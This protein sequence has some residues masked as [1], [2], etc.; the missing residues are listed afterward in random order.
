MRP[1]SSNERMNILFNTSNSSNSVVQTVLPVRYYSTNWVSSLCSHRRGLPQRNF[2]ETLR[3]RHAFMPN[4]PTRYAWR[5]CGWSWPIGLVPPGIDHS[6]NDHHSHYRTTTNT[7]TK[8]KQT[9]D[10]GLVLAFASIVACL[11]HDV[12][13]PSSGSPRPR[14]TVVLCTIGSVSP[15]KRIPRVY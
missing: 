15:F 8:Q 7:D 14:G 11:V 12:C 10:I 4:F 9:I 13:V 1:R 5:S 3:Q 2:L 6:D